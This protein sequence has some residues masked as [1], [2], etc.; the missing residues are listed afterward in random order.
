MTQC[1]ALGIHLIL[2]ATLWSNCCNHCSHFTD[3]ETEIYSLA[4][5]LIPAGAD[6]W[7]DQNL[8]LSSLVLEPVFLFLGEGNGNPLQ[9]ACLENS[10]DGGAW[11]ATVHR[12]AKRRT[13]LSDF[14]FTF[15]TAILPFR[16]SYRLWKLGSQNLNSKILA[17]LIVEQKDLRGFSIWVYTFP[18][19]CGINHISVIV[20]KNT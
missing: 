1:Q 2:T 17:L 9:Y 6:K 19:L 15:L 14:T 16:T 12:V 4:S 20:R 10:V 18:K 8:N 11:W 13:Q 3:E 5:L 7:Q